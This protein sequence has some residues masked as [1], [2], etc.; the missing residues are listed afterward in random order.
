MKILRIIIR[1]RISSVNT[2][3]LTCK[4]NGTWFQQ[5]I[6]SAMYINNMIKD[7]IKQTLE[8]IYENHKIKF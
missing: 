8:E 7:N 2:F 4:K 5:K 3:V 6:F 1:G